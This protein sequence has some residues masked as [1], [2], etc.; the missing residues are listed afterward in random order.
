MT[1]TLGKFTTG[2]LLVMILL[3]ASASGVFAATVE[4]AAAK[5][6]QEQHSA[7]NSGHEPEERAQADR[8]MDRFEKVAALIAERLGVSG[9]Q[10]DQA[11]REGP[12]ALAELGIDPKALRRVFRAKISA[13]RER[14]EAPWEQEDTEVAARI[15]D[16]FGLS[17]DELALAVDTLR[18]LGINPPALGRAL[19]L[20]QAQSR[21]AETGTEPRFWGRNRDAKDQGPDTAYRSGPRGYGAKAKPTSLDAWAVLEQT[22]YKLGIPPAKLK[23]AFH[24]S[25][26]ELAW[27]S[28]L[29]M[30]PDFKQYTDY[31][32]RSYQSDRM[33]RYGQEDL[34]HGF[35]RRNRAA[36]QGRH[37]R[38]HR[39][40]AGAAVRPERPDKNGF[41]MPNRPAP[42]S[43]DH[44]GGTEHAAGTHGDAE[45]EA[46]SLPIHNVLPVF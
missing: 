30:K 43:A 2:L 26:M 13:T 5:S 27:A 8:T 4:E 44:K 41:S 9:E 14:P 7:E 40:S 37:D 3:L 31:G 29:G 28:S 32:D 39:D 16:H 20:A 25:V 18:E 23:A 42:E 12:A 6:G 19:E 1:Q 24:T 22:A 36:W 46:Q 38:K 33:D 15:A 34:H 45:E 11:L 17:V 21:L 35:Q 10:L